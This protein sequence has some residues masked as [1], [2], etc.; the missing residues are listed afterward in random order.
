MA[1][2]PYVMKKMAALVMPS[3]IT[4]IMFAVGIIFYDLIIAIG[5]MFLGLLIG[6]FTAG[7]ILK[8]PFTD[9]I[10]GRGLMVANMDST[11]IVTPFLVQVQTPY[12]RGK[13]GN[14]PVEDVFD[15]DAMFQMAAPVKVA[16]QAEFAEITKNLREDSATGQWI[17]ETETILRIELNKKAYNEG[18]FALQHWPLII[19]NAQMGTVIPKDWFAGKEVEAFAKHGIFYLNRKVEE[20]NSHIRDFGRYIVDTLKPK[21]S[22]FSSK[23]AIIVM[24]VVF[25]LLAVLFA[26]PVIDLVSGI[27]AG[28]ANA[29]QAGGGNT[30]TPQ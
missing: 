22:L 27:G 29:V 7:L 2:N 1:L 9:M 14:K 4:T 25:I 24:I 10:E 8:N 17:Y 15:R 16:Q 13:L 21:T 20:L 26:R 3:L 28:A 19:Y 11:G 5:L 23:L 18:R 30:I 6:Y 12:I